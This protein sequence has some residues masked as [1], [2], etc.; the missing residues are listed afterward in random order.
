VSTHNILASKSGGG[1]GVRC[2]TSK[3]DGYSRR[4][5]LIRAVTAPTP[6][7][8]QFLLEGRKFQMF[9]LR[10]SKLLARKVVLCF[11]RRVHQVSVWTLDV[12]AAPRSVPEW[13]AGFNGPRVSV[14]RQAKSKFVNRARRKT[15]TSFLRSV[16]SDC[17]FV[18]N[19]ILF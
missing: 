4:G 6:S 1:G 11:R 14:A 12:S 10:A 5:S 13:R 18:T 9:K 8:Y 2:H 3:L 15:D 16:S 17:V 19:L 7:K